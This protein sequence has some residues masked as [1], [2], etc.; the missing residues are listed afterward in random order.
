MNRKNAVLERLN[1]KYDEWY[2]KLYKD[3]DLELSLYNKADEFDNRRD[4]AYFIALLNIF[5]NYRQDLILSDR[6]AMAFV[7]ACENLFKD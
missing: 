2:E 5:A 4:D 7:L 3:R 1:A 6:E